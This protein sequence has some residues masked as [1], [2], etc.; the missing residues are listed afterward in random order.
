[1]TMAPFA[2][3]TTLARTY[4][5]EARV[6]PQSKAKLMFL[7]PWCGDISHCGRID[8]KGKNFFSWKHK[9]NSFLVFQQNNDIF[10][11]FV[12]KPSSFSMHYILY[13]FWRISVKSILCTYTKYIGS[14]FH[15]F[16]VKMII[17][18]TIFFIFNIEFSYP[19]VCRRY[20]AEKTLTRSRSALIQW[21][22]LNLLGLEKG[23][24]LNLTKKSIC[25]SIFWGSK[26]YP[27]S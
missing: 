7:L 17:F 10:R 1:M 11:Q 6:Q 21:G 27:N 19:T 3:Y 26:S 18:P 12:E 23:V 20:K 4:L 14:Q 13:S 25:S 2:Y 5:C 15:E 24:V 22:Q 16:S 8:E 9:S